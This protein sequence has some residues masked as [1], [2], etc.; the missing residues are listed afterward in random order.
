M[1]LL[2]CIGGLVYNLLGARGN[3]LA[4]NVVMAMVR[5]VA[6]RVGWSFAKRMRI[7][8]DGATF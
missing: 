4:M 8:G 7:L 2:A 3:N 1:T 5:D 6:S